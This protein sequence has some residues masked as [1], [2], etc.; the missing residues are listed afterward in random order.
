MDAGG[1]SSGW[2]VLG[3]VGDI[4]AVREKFWHSDRYKDDLRY[5]KVWLE[6]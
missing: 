1:V 2:R 6:M 4:R 5:L 3:S